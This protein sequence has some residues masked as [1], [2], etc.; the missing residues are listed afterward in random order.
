M[1][2]EAFDPSS[3][4]SGTACPTSCALTLVRKA[5]LTNLAQ[6][7]GDLRVP[8]ELVAV[9]VL[10]HERAGKVSHLEMRARQVVEEEAGVDRGRDPD[11][12]DLRDVAV[13]ELDFNAR[14]IVQQG[15][16]GHEY[17]WLLNLSRRGDNAWNREA[18]RE[19]PLA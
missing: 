8:R 6:A 18:G 7:S 2:A 1:L 14:S 13:L 4:G 3:V 17:R 5:V 15:F 16:A 9:R 11:Q 10:E 12:W 19:V